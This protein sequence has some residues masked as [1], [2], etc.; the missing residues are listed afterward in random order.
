MSAMNTTAITVEK[1]KAGNY[2]VGTNA[3][4]K[5]YLGETEVEAYLRARGDWDDLSEV[6]GDL[7]QAEADLVN[8]LN[9]AED[10]RSSIRG[11]I[12]SIR[13]ILS[14]PDNIGAIK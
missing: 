9:N 12:E 3:E 4:G 11:L 5:S 14:L 7:E 10:S 6:A 8:P 13:L 1:H 2:W